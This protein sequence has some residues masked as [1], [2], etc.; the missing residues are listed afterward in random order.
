M[1]RALVGIFMGSSFLLGNRLAYLER[2]IAKNYRFSNRKSRIKFSGSA[3]AKFR[4]KGGG[5][6]QVAE[7]GS[8][9]IQQINSKPL[10]DAVC[11]NRGQDPMEIQFQDNGRRLWPKPAKR[12]VYDFT[13]RATRPM[14]RALLRGIV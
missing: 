11:I 10:H 6:K 2:S 14:S 7:T 5:S 3:S 12:P 9:W 4:M 8:G 13:L 1:E